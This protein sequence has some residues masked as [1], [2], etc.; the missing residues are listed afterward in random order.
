VERDL[1]THKTRSQ[2]TKTLEQK[3]KDKRDKLRNNFQDEI[4][5][6][7]DHLASIGEALKM[8]DVPETDWIK[9]FSERI[10]S[11]ILESIPLPELLRES[12]K[13]VRDVYTKHKEIEET[14]EATEK[15]NRTREFVLIKHQDLIKMQEDF[16][17]FLREYNKILE[18]GD[19]VLMTDA[20]KKLSNIKDD[21]NLTKIARIYGQTIYQSFILETGE[22]RGVH[23][24]CSLSPGERTRK[25]QQKCYNK[26]QKL[27]DSI[28][29]ELEYPSFV[30]I[31]Y[32]PY[33]YQ[34]IRSCNISKK[35]LEYIFKPIEEGGAGFK[36]IIEFFNWWRKN[37]MLRS[38]PYI[39]G[40]DYVDFIK[41]K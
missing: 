41:C 18:S 10:T 39:M 28:R 35:V 5:L 29:R 3:L 13:I 16:D 22:L 26:Q 15:M 12:L 40:S 4:N 36:N 11:E 23:V 27:R 6:Y 21:R 32:E 25:R 8:K 20:W 17:W 38:E 37:T 2:F 24:V 9:L 14:A 1:T 31:R 30:E 19:I 33:K 7:Q 34:A